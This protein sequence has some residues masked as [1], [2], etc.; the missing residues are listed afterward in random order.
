M[1]SRSRVVIHS[2]VYYTVHPRAKKSR[3]HKIITRSAHNKTSASL[4]TRE[5]ERDRDDDGPG[6]EIA[7][8]ADTAETR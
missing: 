4:T 7:V 6:D 8:C 2:V 1:A 3:R 5:K